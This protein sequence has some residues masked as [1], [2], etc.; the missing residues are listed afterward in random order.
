MENSFYRDNITEVSVKEISNKLS[1]KDNI[2]FIGSCFAGNLYKTLNSYF[3]NVETSPFGNVY[4][5]ASIGKSLSI[6][7]DKRF[8]SKDECIQ[9]DGLYQHFDFHSSNGNPESSIFIDTINKKIEASTRFLKSSDVIVLTLGTAFV[10]RYKGRIVNNCHKLKKSDFT[11]TPLTVNEIRESITYPL[12]ILKEINPQLK[13]ILTL[14]PV[15]HL[16][17]DASENS[18]SKALL[19][20]A[21]E[22]IVKETGAYYFPS[23]EIVLDELRDYRWFDESMTH[24][25]EKAVGYIMKKF[26]DSTYD[27]EMQIYIKKID[28]LT[29]MLN[30]KVMN[31]DSESAQKFYKKL[32]STRERLIKEYPEIKA[33]QNR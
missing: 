26:I 16:R 9:Q 20:V 31:P 2:F 24:P 8:I 32:E 30:H 10:Y 17:D 7:L 1:W 15:R 33:L 28:K 3:L 23:Y 4:N 29:R 19:R 25:S 21:I 22:E 14:S 6:L 27:D 11:R 18:Y 13:I 5:P 12:K